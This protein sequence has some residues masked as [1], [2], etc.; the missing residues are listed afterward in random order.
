MAVRVLATCCSRELSGPC[1][2]SCEE[3]RMAER[4]CC[5]AAVRHCC[6][7]GELLL[8]R[9]LYKGVRIPSQILEVLIDHTCLIWPPPKVC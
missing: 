1:L 8:Q 7:W 3:V 4:W 5:E 2:Q 6:S 9:G